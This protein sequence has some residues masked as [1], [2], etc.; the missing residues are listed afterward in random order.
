M[1]TPHCQNLRSPRRPVPSEFLVDGSGAGASPWLSCGKSSSSN[2]HV[3]TCM[4][5]F[6]C[7]FFD[8]E[9]D[10]KTALCQRVGSR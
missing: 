9:Q 5:S 7:E 10:W 4:V 8:G 2:L 1:E 3:R 6:L